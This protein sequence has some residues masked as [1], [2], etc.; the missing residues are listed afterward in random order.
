MPRE[1]WRVMAEP[2]QKDPSP[3]AKALSARLLAVQALYQSFQL[4]QPISAAMQEY[5]DHRIEMDIEGEKLIKP[6]GVLFSRIL[7]GIEARLQDLGPI[8][9]AHVKK[10]HETRPSEPLIKAIITCGCYEIFAH[11][12][13]DSPVIINDYLNVAHGFYDKGEVAF[14]NGVLDSIAKTLRPAPEKA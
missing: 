12:D 11:Q 13:I 9:T 4:T 14:I 7:T 10:K 2:V 8:I 1:S 3:K 6:D 5:L